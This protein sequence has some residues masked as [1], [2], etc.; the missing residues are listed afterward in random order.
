MTE[1]MTTT[2]LQRNE[3]IRNTQVPSVSDVKVKKTAERIVQTNT[4]STSMRTGRNYTSTEM[5]NGTNMKRVW[6]NRK[7]EQKLVLGKDMGD[8]LS[9]PH[10]LSH[11]E[12]HTFN[13]SLYRLIKV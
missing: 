10:K 11:H 5:K 9:N 1:A 12:I 4:C 13:S 3:G 6:C 2:T 8:E 7:D